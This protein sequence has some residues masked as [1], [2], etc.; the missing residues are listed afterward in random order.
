VRHP[1]HNGASSMC[2][3]QIWSTLRTHLGRGPP[4]FLRSLR[5]FAYRLQHVSE[6][7][8]ARV[9]NLQPLRTPVNLRT[10]SEPLVEKAFSGGQPFWSAANVA[11]ILITILSRP[12][13]KLSYDE[14]LGGNCEKPVG[15]R[16]GVNGR[17]LNTTARNRA[18]VSSCDLAPK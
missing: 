11:F 4:G 8:H 9:D 15:V 1:F 14:P 7:H 2:S 12:F 6:I 18:Q 17:K 16:R 5:C 3:D 10:H 13:T